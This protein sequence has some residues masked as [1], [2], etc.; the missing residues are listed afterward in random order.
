MDQILACEIR[1]HSLKVGG[2]VLSEESRFSKT[3][4]LFSYMHSIF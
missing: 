2:R 3:L 4:M 1:T